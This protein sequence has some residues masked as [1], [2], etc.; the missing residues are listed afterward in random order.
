[1]KRLEKEEIKE[2]VDIRKKGISYRKIARRF[3]RSLDT[4]L[5]YCKNVKLSESIKLKLKREVE[6]RQ[7]I[8]I[9][10]YAK[11]KPIKYSSINKNKANLLGHIFFDGHLRNEKGRHLITYTNS[12]LFAINNFVKL[13]KREFALDC[14]KIYTGK[15]VSVYH[16]AVFLSKILVENLIRDF[17]EF[18]TK[19]GARVPDIIKRSNE[20]IRVSFLRAFWDDE[21]SISHYGA[22]QGCSKSE[23]MIKDLVDMHRELGIDC[24]EQKSKG[25]SYI[26]IS[27]KINNMKKFHK[28]V[29]FEFGK[30]TRGKNKERFK[31]DV[32]HEF[33]YGT[34]AQPE[35]EIYFG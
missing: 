18:S 22:L 25:Y 12:S 35:K 33:L 14:N 16:T 3:N 11:V 31:K 2:V 27:K 19:K 15:I 5:K 20:N 7:K 1:M 13:M 32:L 4:V 26:A 24:T 10:K 17:G 34:V 8:F 29:G 6:K 30:I 28:K 9:K 21:G 23:M